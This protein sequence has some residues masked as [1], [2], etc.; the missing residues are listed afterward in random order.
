MSIVNECLVVNLQ[1]GI[2]TGQRLDK[3][4]SRKVTEEANAD[5]DAARVN[6]HLIP[7][8][9]MKPIVTAANSIRTHFYS[10]TLPWKDN[11][12]R[13]I[14]RAAFFRFIEEHERLV[15]SFQNEVQKFG[16]EG[17]PSA[18]EKAGFRMGDLHNPDD[19]PSPAEVKRRFY[20][21][22]DIDPVTEAADFR[23]QMD[24]KQTEAIK[25]SMER[26]MNERVGRAMASVWERLGD[27]L[28][29]FAERTKTGSGIRV[30]LV[31]NLREIVNILPELNITNDPQLE[32][33]RRQIEAKLTGYEASEL[34]QDDTA[35]SVAAR[36]A[37]KIMDQM[38]G[39]MTA[40]GAA[41]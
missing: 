19:Y 30:E 37:Q 29:N 11:G 15:G 38:R 23:V 28:G 41:A 13:V 7:K 16:D 3:E 9:S 31:E 2:W 18:V 6:K 22:L 25:A 20:V 8:E 24:A 12:D 34:R 4:A 1:L 27:V 35:R 39:F 40:F 33:I 21:N 26:A 36:D 5:S 10:N 14:S 17:Y 32:V